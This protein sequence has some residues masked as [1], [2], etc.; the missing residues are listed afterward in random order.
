MAGAECGRQSRSGR[1]DSAGDAQCAATAL[2]IGFWHNDEGRL[3]AWPSGGDC[4][5]A[6]AG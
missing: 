1:G 6:I 3:W 2:N 5:G 4:A